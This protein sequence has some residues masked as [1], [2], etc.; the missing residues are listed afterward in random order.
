MN[1]YGSFDEAITGISNKITLKKFNITDKN[2]QEIFN[3]QEKIKIFLIEMK[4]NEGEVK[5]NI[6]A[7]YDTIIKENPELESEKGLLLDVANYVAL[8]VEETGITSPE[9]IKATSGMTAEILKN[10]TNNTNNYKNENKTT[11]ETI[12][13]IAIFEITKE[14]LENFQ[15]NMQEEYKHNYFQAEDFEEVKR[16]NEEITAIVGKE[17]I[18]ILIQKANTGDREAARILMIVQNAQI[19]LG[20]N[21]NIDKIPEDRL[22]E[23]LKDMILLLEYTDIPEIRKIYEKMS[24]KLPEEY[25]EKSDDEQKIASSEKLRQAYK[26]TNNGK[27]IDIKFIKETYDELAG[28]YIQNSEY[29]FINGVEDFTIE[30]TIEG[31]KRMLQRNFS[32]CQEKADKS[33]EDYKYALYELRENSKKYLDASLRMAEEMVLAGIENSDSEI[34]ENLMKFVVDGLIEA[35]EGK[36]FVDDE[37]TKASKKN[38]FKA[39]INNKEFCTPELL[40]KIA[41]ADSGVAKEVLKELLEEY[42]I[43]SDK[44]IG[45]KIQ[46]LSNAI[47]TVGQEEKILIEKIKKETIN[48]EYDAR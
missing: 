26:I 2:K 42:N 13:N 11:Y 6:S 10:I 7:I 17:N 32:I 41:R 34:F 46:L 47:K 9:Q 3:D 22:Q 8:Q 29:Q 4:K 16:Q 21:S 40:E 27:D 25:L 37:Y 48:D 39:V 12:Q 35:K 1:R 28:Q 44:T 18:E 45:E 19:T 38:L 24:E 43:T 33:P 5:T 14:G 31:Q 36:E 20:Y 15:K 30:N 23:Y